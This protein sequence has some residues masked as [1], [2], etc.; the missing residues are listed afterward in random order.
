MKIA[1]AVVISAGLDLL[2]RGYKVRIGTGSLSDRVCNSNILRGQ[3]HKMR[4]VAIHSNAP[5][6]CPP[7]CK[8]DC[9][10]PY[11]LGFAWSGTMVYH[12]PTSSLR[13]DLAQELTFTVSGSSPGTGTDGYAGHSHYE[14]SATYAPAVI[15][16]TG[17][18][19]FGADAE[20]LENPY[21]WEWWD[22]RGWPGGLSGALTGTS[23][24]SEAS[25][26][27][28]RTDLERVGRRGVPQGLI[29]EQGTNLDY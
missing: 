10:P 7:D 8:W 17:Y 23:P 4:H 22:Q 14:T 19:T 21:N 18:H 1:N 12:Y 9:T 15:L 20:W 3:T 28:G 11:N 5:S 16:E 2:E 26:V 13:S 27:P 25:G 24:I 29:L 6:G